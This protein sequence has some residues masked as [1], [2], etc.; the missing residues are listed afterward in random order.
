MKNKIK[1][2]PLIIVS[3]NLI[4]LIM[5]K[6]NLIGFS[7]EIWGFIIVVITVINLNILWILITKG[8]IFLKENK[9]IKE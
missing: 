1:W 7:P 4:L 6:S 2:L 3:I 9:N 5:L 8:N